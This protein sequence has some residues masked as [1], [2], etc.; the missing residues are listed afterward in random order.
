MQKNIVS[1]L[2]WLVCISLLTACSSSKNTTRFYSLTDL[3]QQV[4]KDR[5]Q[6]SIGVGPVHIPRLLRRPQLVLRKNKT[7]VSLVELHQW[8]GSLREDILSSLSRN[9]STLLGSDRIERY[10]WKNTQRPQ[11]QVRINIEQLDGD[12]G[13]TVNLKARWSLLKNN[14]PIL[15]KHSDIKVK[16]QGNDYNAYV[17]AQSQALYQLAQAIIVPL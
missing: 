11:Y 1:L 6:L 15:R 3:A 17:T 9:L 7:E 10:P 4:Q 12:L 2:L 8:G 5:P 14:K 16:V 13:K